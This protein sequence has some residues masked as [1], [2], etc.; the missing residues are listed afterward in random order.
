MPLISQEYLLTPWMSIL[1]IGVPYS[2]KTRSLVTMHEYM[3]MK[4]QLFANLRIYDLDGNSDPVVRLAR[5]GG[6]LKELQ[7]Y[8]YSTRRGGKK[9]KKEVAP[10]RSVEEF[11][12]FMDEFNEMYDMVDP[13]TGF[14]RE[15]AIN[16]PGCVVIDSGTA[17]EDLIYD[18]VLTKRGREFGEGEMITQGKNAGRTTKDV[19]GSDW[20]SIKDKEVEVIESA[21]GLPCHFIYICHETTVQEVVPGPQVRVEGAAIAPIPTGAILSQPAL[22]GNLRDTMPKY[23]SAV[24]FSSREGDQA[25]WQ[26]RPGG[27]IKMAGTR[28]RDDLPQFVPQDYKGILL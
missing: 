16:P 13:R 18:F 24:L 7:V 26:V 22:T 17:L 27:R 5:D 8:K 4:K 21:K 20:S 19:T 25:K 23:F 10:A 28:L 15:G 11:D 12:N 1:N 6:W 9:I 14:W 2:G 3:I